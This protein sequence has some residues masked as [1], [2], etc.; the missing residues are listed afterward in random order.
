VDDRPVYSFV[1]TNDAGEQVR[2]FKFAFTE[3]K[4]DTCLGRGWKRVKVV[5]D[6]GNYTEDPVYRLENAR[7]EVLLRNSVC[8]AYDSYIGEVKKDGSFSGN[9][10]LYG[11]SS[12]TIG[13]V[14]GSLSMP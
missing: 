8:D 14:T 4:G 6:A 1:E 10:V 13:S 12:K 2:V 5:Y 3:S 11:W 9:H 7:L